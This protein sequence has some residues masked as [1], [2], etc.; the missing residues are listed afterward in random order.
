M[1]QLRLDQGAVLLKQAVT[2]LVEMVRFADIRISPEDLTLVSA[3]NYP[4]FPQVFI[5]LRMRSLMFAH[6]RCN[7]TRWICINLRHLFSALALARSEDS[8][9]IHG[10]E[11][12]DVVGFLFNNP[13]THRVRYSEMALIGVYPADQMQAG[14][15]NFKYQV[16]VGIPSV[17]FQRQLIRLRCFG[18]TVYARITDTEV[19]LSVA[20]EEVLLTNE[21]CIIGGDV[22]EEDPVTAVF[23][24]H[25]LSA[26]LKA[27]HL[28]S[29]VWLLH[30]N[31]LLPFCMLNFPVGALGNLMFHFPPPEDGDET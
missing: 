26:I 3:S 1:F 7:E 22:S 10:D 13:R 18:E 2:P 27:S 29:R 11:G 12:E 15:A 21:N 19:R 16:I 28:T 17:E 14:F 30:S 31:S 23:S 9:E 4:R 24:L 8:I 6:F 20:N 5:A 25:C